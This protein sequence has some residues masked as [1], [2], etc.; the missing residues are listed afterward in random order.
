MQAIE[1][2]ADA[3]IEQENELLNQP[4]GFVSMPAWIGVAKEIKERFVE[5]RDK[6]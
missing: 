3:V 2:L 5:N 6:F 1:Q 4:P